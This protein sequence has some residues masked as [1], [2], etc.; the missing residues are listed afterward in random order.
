[1]KSHHILAP[2]LLLCTLASCG[3]TPTGSDAQ[4]RPGGASFD[5][6]GF[7]M[8]GGRSEPDTTGTTT[9]STPTSP[10]GT[11]RGGGFGMGGG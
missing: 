8:G 9:T 2:A 4:A 10:E 7:G 6:G 3:Q 11:E 5:G 1:M